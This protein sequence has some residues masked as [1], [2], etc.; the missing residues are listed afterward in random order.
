[1]IRLIEITGEQQDELSRC[2]FYTVARNLALEIMAD[3]EA[4]TV[5]NRPEEK[6]V[7]YR[8]LLNSLEMILEWE[9]ELGEDIKQLTR[10]EYC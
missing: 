4:V 1:M 7:I 9:S 3:I 5:S 2:I 6:I 8:G 10:D